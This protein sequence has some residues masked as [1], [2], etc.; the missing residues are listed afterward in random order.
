MAAKNSQVSG[1]NTVGQSK[2]VLLLI[3][4]ISDFEFEDG[5]QLFKYALPA[6]RKIAALKKGQKRQEL[7]RFTSMTISVNGATIF[8]RQFNTV[9]KTN[10][11]ER[12]SSNY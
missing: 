4:L 11:A 12:K 8:K 10:F 1:N 3:D 5:E 2:I 6:A 7:R 9:Y